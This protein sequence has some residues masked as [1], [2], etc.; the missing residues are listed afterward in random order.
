V[1]EY[2]AKHLSAVFPSLL[3]GAVLTVQVTALS[4]MFGIIIGMFT[5]MGKLSKNKIIRV[6]CS[7]Y[8]DLIRGTPLLVQVFLIYFGLPNLILQITGNRFPIDPFVAAIWACSINSGAYVAEIFRSGIQSIEK[9]QMEA[10]R[11]LGMNKAQAMRYVILPQAIR[12]IIPPLG[13]EFIALMKDTSILSAI[14]LEELVRKGQLYTSST[15]ASFP[16]YTG[17]M[18]VYLVMTMVVS[19]FVTYMERRLKVVDRG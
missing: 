19:R 9:G 8:V 13:N 6:I 1:L 16:V 2:Y 3:K 15:F 7:A 12:R 4:E 14:G 18:F 5:G 11:S 17:V 10:A